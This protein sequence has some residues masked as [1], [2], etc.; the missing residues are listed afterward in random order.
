LRTSLHVL[1]LHMCVIFEDM[2]IQI[3]CLVFHWVITYF[4]FGFWFLLLF[5]LPFFIFA[6]LGFALRVSLLQNRCFTA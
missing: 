3:I 2:S 4:L 5:F 1:I 6:G